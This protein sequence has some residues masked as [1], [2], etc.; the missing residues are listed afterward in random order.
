[1]KQKQYCKKF[2]KDI[3]NSTNQKKKKKKKKKKVTWYQLPRVQVC[4]LTQF[5]KMH[6][7]QE[8]KE[9]LEGSDGAQ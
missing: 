4:Y 7:R 9:P 2:C 8:R 5:W 1:M 6:L 3:K